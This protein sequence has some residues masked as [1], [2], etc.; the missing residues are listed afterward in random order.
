MYL[1]LTQYTWAFNSS[2]QDTRKCHHF[3]P[4]VMGSFNSSF[5]DTT[6]G[7]EG[8]LPAQI[9]FQFLILGYKHVQQSHAPYSV[10]LSIPHFRIL[11]LFVDASANDGFQFLILGY[12]YI[13]ATG[14]TTILFQFLILGYSSIFRIPPPRYDYFQFLILGYSSTVATVGLVVFYY[15]QFLILGYEMG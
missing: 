15:F 14:M 7:Q 11:N 1:M 8:A 6:L 3:V 13:D 9:N 5:Q 2:F 12:L 4:T 10:I